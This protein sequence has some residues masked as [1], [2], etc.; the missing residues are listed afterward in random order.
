M[1]D[2]INPNY[3]IGTKI[4]VSDFIEEFD[5]NY[6][7]GN[8]IKYVTRHRKKN[9]LEDLRK[10]KWYIERLIDGYTEIKKSNH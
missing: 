8:V 2:K 9:G 10:A 5:L 7:E 1:K 3:Y 4:Q 6:F